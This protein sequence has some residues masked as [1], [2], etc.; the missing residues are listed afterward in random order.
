MTAPDAGRDGPG[1]ALRRVGLVHEEAYFWHLSRVGFGGIVEGDSQ[2]E[3]PEPRRRLLNLLHRLGLTDL[4]IRVRADELT[5][6]DLRRVHAPEYLN[7]L[8]AADATGG[9][10]GE[11]APF[12]PGSFA[13]ARLAAGGVHAAVDATLAGRT[14][15]AFALV[16]PPG[17]HA[18]RERGRGFCLLA[19]VAIAVEKARSQHG[20]GRVAI[21][22]WDVHHGNGAQSLYYD[23]PMTLTVSI[24][25]D[26]LYPKDSGMVEETGGPGAPGGNVNVPLPPGSGEG[27]YLHAWDHVVAPAIEHFGPDLLVVSCGFDASQC[28][29]SGRMLLTAGSFSL[30]TQRALA[31]ADRTCRGRL[32]LAQEGGYSA[33]YMPICGAAVVATL[34][35]DGG[36]VDDP[37]ATIGDVSHQGLQPHQERVIT[38]ARRLHEHALRSRN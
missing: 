33:I 14:D 31:L 34:L 16:R 13:I 10:A 9:E 38:L 24:H 6:Q 7:R 23:D 1:S 29:P 18:E 37:L 20:L 27:A 21:I 5:E 25:Q 30:L 4:C 15:V 28:D 2:F 12:G 36:L 35:G 3:T 26:R 8:L 32:V 22:D 17:H 19:N 11:S